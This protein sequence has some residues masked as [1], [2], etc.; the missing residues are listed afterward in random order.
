MTVTYGEWA[1]A[2]LKECSLSATNVTL[3]ATLAWMVSEYAIE[4]PLN[5]RALNNPLDTKEPYPNA[6]DFHNLGVKNYAT[7]ED[8]LSATLRTIENGDYSAILEAYVNATNPFDITNAIVASPWGSK[9][10]FPIVHYV[11]DNYDSVYNAAANVTKGSSTATSVEGSSN[12][13]GEVESATGTPLA[14]PI[15]SSCP[16]PTGRGYYLVGADGGVFAFGDAKYHGSIPELVAAKQSEPVTSPVVSIM[17]IDNNG[18]WLVCA[19]G[20]VYAFGAAQFQGA[21]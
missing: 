3:Q 12:A 10:T 13:T 6:T 19:D 9:P 21:I 5:Q 18:Y 16:S 2:F 15:V 7:M 8:G 14:A 1:T 11:Q 17:A 4:V 20:A